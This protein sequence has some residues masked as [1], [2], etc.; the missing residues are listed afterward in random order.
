VT[1][2]PL[3]VSAI[4]S[5]N[6]EAVKSLLDAGVD[7]TELVFDY[8]FD[9]N[10]PWQTG[11]KGTATH[12]AAYECKV[13]VLRLLAQH[14]PDTLFKVSQRGIDPNHYGGHGDPHWVDG[15]L[16]IMVPLCH[17]SRLIFY[18]D[19]PPQMYTREREHLSDLCD[20]VLLLAEMAPERLFA[21]EYCPIHMAVRFDV[22]LTRRLAEL[23]PDTLMPPSWVRTV[24]SGWRCHSCVQPSAWDHSS[25]RCNLPL[26]LV[27]RDSKYN[28]DD[29]RFFVALAPDSV[30]ATNSVSIGESGGWVSVLAPD[31]FVCSWVNFLCMV[32]LISM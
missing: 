21:K 13:D 14:S 4:K 32:P 5:N 29:V 3:Q 1:F 28:V 16:P 11:D 15:D 2:E 27:C 24:S 10:I 8:G 12:L 20:T 31:A 9:K 19:A 17:H 23:A 30:T 22:K 18:I 6:V 7:P 25:G 26:H